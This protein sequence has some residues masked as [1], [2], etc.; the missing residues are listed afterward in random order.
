MN[1][2]QTHK[3]PR[4]GFFA[5]IGGGL[6]ALGL[7]TLSKPLSLVAQE[8]V[9]QKS[10]SQDPAEQWFKK[11]KGSHRVVY[12]STQPHDIFPFVWPKVFLLTNEATGTPA[13]DC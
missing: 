6:A 1:N 4:R 12:D 8:K 13:S 10:A 5:A 7:T 9:A 11:I 3:T 2:N